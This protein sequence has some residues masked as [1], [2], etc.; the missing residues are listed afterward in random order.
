MRTIRLCCITCG[1]DRTS[2]D[3]HSS[4]EHLVD[5]DIDMVMRTIDRVECGETEVYIVPN[6]VTWEIP[7][8]LHALRMVR[9]HMET[10]DF[11]EFEECD[12][13][14]LEEVNDAILDVERWLR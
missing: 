8:M 6:D 1:E 3:R 9:K 11:M 2:E 10:D 4:C 14:V 7:R 12:S 13:D 5:G